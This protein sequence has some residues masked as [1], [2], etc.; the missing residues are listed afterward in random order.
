MYLRIHSWFP[1][2]PVHHL[3]LVEWNYFQCQLTQDLFQAIASDKGPLRTKIKETKLMRH[4]TVSLVAQLPS[5]E[6]DNFSFPF[7][8]RLQESVTKVIWVNAN[9]VKIEFL[10]SVQRK[11]SIWIYRTYI[12]ICI[13]DINITTSRTASGLKHIITL[14]TIEE[15]KQSELTARIGKQLS[16]WNNRKIQ[17]HDKAMLPL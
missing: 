2:F 9:L 3:G 13:L 10:H 12:W 16:N 6:L 17:S 7:C 15:L 14:F 11:V 1:C 4:G 8:D 5:K